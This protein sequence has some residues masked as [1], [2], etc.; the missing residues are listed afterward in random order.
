MHGLSPFLC[1]GQGKVQA[2]LG[3]AYICERFC[4]RRRTI[5]FPV[6][7]LA[8]QKWGTLCKNASNHLRKYVLVHVCPTAQTFPSVF[9]L[10]RSVFRMQF[11]SSPSTLSSKGKQ[12]RTEGS[13]DRPLFLLS[14]SSSF[15]YIQQQLL[16]SRCIPGVST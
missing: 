7:K 8:Y 4:R 6:P 13:R 15:V 11:P 2:N 12:E 1:N 9:F 5:P 16:S 14:F 3:S 10:W